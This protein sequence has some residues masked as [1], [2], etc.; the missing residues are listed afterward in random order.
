[1]KKGVIV[2]LMI[3]SMALMH[4]PRASADS[5]WDMAESEHYGR[6]AGGMLGRGLVNAATSPMDLIVQTVEKTQEGPPLF[7]TLNG[8]ASGLGCTALR[9]SSGILDVATFWV[10]GWNG[11]TVSRS[12]SNCL[13][14]SAPAP[15]VEPPA[16]SAPVVVEEH[17]PMDYVKKGLYDQPAPQQ[18]RARYIK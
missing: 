11:F 10:P 16:Q 12:Y 17:N 2:F 13:A 3:L 5:V 7:G 18:E 15:Y 14:E 4:A 6:K 9:A 8:L 1:M